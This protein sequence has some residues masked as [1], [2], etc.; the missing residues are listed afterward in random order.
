MPKSNPTKRRAKT[1]AD[2][3]ET[4]PVEVDHVKPKA[5]INRRMKLGEQAKTKPVT[6][7]FR[8][9]LINTRKSPYKLAPL[10][11]ITPPAVY[12]FLTGQGGLSLDVIDRLSVSLGIEF[13]IVWAGYPEGT[14]E[15]QKQMEMVISPRAAHELP[16][17]RR[18]GLKE[19]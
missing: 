16:L 9:L 1:T 8:A 11:G 5:E 17:P 12:R 6:T 7:A 14:Q 13:H 10:A 15:E 18:S 4:K 2:E 19:P 3:S